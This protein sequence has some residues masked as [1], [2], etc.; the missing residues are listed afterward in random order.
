[1]TEI[2]PF[3]LLTL[4]ALNTAQDWEPA[5]SLPLPENPTSELLDRA[6]EQV[7]Q[8]LDFYLNDCAPN[9]PDDELRREI[10]RAAERLIEIGM[11]AGPAHQRD[12]DEGLAHDRAER[13][14]QRNGKTTE[15]ES[16][17][18]AWRLLLSDDPAEIAEVETV[19]GLTQAKTVD[20][21]IEETCWRDAVREFVGHKGTP[22]QRLEALREAYYREPRARAA[23]D[24]SRRERIL[25]HYGPP[26][27]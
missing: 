21:F 22:R 15:E 3:P 4:E 10:M 19:Y 5:L 24:Q 20:M 1:M 2:V 13:E 26:I 14:C 7:L 6:R 17:D 8:Y 27:V 18:T 9:A 16:G 11:A 12:I 23:E 25:R